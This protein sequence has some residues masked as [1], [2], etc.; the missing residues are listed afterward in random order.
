MPT[1]VVMPQMGES[2]AEG[3]IVR[4]IK[5]VGDQVAR[6]EPLF[7]IDRQGGRKFLRRRQGSSRRIR[8]KEGET[9]SRQQR[10]RGG[11]VLPASRRKLQRRTPP[12]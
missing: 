11:S 6:D 10:G 8:V 5:K 7:E 2:I 4:W 3:T 12:P 9:V 1:D